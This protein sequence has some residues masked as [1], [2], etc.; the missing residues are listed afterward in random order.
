[1]KNLRHALVALAALGC[2]ALSP[3]FASAQSNAQSDGLEG[4]HGWSRAHMFG[5]GSRLTGRIGTYMLGG[6]GGHVRLRPLRWIAVEAFTDHVFGS[7]DSTL[8]HDHEGGVSLQFPF[9][10]NRWWNVYPLIGACASLVVLEPPRQG[11]A[12]V[13]DIHFGFRGGAGSEIYLNDHWALRAQVEGIGYIGHNLR[14]YNWTAQLSPEV[15][16]SGVAQASLSVNLY[17]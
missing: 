3:V 2:T 8:R 11:G 16:L 7:V 5:M 15:S 10:G 6:V 4:G 14:A 17:L 9:L 1:M 13:S 12:F